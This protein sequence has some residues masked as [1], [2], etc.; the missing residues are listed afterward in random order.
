M[1]FGGKYA[2]GSSRE[3]NQGAHHACDEGES[4]DNIEGAYDLFAS[5]RDNVLKVA[6][7]V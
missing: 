7:S 5:H 1:T 6:V 2:I 3:Q 4:L